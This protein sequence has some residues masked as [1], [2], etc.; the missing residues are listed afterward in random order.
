MAPRMEIPDSV[1]SELAVYLIR[2][3][4]LVNRCHFDCRRDQMGRPQRSS[5]TVCDETAKALTS[6]H[7]PSAD[8]VSFAEGDA[9]G[10]TA[11]SGGRRRSGK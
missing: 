2:E 6:M 4:M 11:C 10:A 1:Q 9:R 5:N 8:G 7:R 3:D